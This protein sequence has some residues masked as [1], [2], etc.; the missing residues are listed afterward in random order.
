[1]RLALAAVLFFWAAAVSFAVSFE[2]AKSAF[3]RQDWKTASV[4]LGE[5]LQEN[6]DDVQAATAA[7]LRGVALYQLGDP[8]AS[9]DAFQKLDRA[10]PQSAYSKQLPYWKGTAALAAGQWALAERELAGQAQYPGQEPYTTR[11][12]FNLA[13]ARI[14]QSEDGSA[15]QALEGFTKASHEPALLAQ[16]WAVWGDL[17]RKAQRSTS[18]VNH[19]RASWEAEPGGRWAL[20]SRTQAVD[21]LMEMGRLDQARILLEAS[22]QLFPAEA[23]RWD[24]RRVNLYR[25]LGDQTTVAKSLEALWGRESDL[26]R[27]QELAANRARTAEDSGKPVADWWLKASDGPDPSLGASA[28]LRYAF[29]VESAG[30][31]VDAAQ[32]LENW[33]QAHGDFVSREDTANRAAEDRLKAGDA[34]GAKKNWDRLIAESAKS[35]KMP[36]WLLARGRVSSGLRRY[37][38]GVGRLQPPLAGLSPGERRARG[39]VSDG[40]GLPASAGAGA[41]RSPGSTASSRISKPENST[42]EPCWLGESVSSTRVRPTWPGEVFRG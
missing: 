22:S 23:D 39:T 41:G 26:G 11:A 21:L 10:W 9:L 34:G 40:F 42:N 2:E 36:A 24:G 31:W 19:Y 3:G 8:R 33:T 37:D 4:L 14:A 12:L 25:K 27:K 5:F 13:L 29:L 28:I 1:M 35:P 20:F 38:S 18:A 7:F 15:A 32:A 17:D 16:A 30:R 6:P